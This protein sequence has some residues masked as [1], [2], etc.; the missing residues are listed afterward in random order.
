MMVET[1][2]SRSVRVIFA[3][4]LAFGAQLAYAQMAQEPVVQRVEITGSSIRR[5]ASETALP[6]TV[7][8]RADIEKSGVQSTEEL[9]AQVNAVSSAGGQVSAAQSGLTTYGKSAVSLRGI[10]SDKTLVLVNG[11][12]LANFAGGA[13]AGADVNVNAI[14]LAAIDRVEVLQDGASGVYGSD[15][16]AGVV[17]FILRKDFNGIEL[18][19]MSGKPTQGGGAKQHKLG[20]VAGWGDYDKD[21]FSIVGSLAYEK[22]GNLLGAARDFA[23]TDT[24]RPY[25]EGGATETGRI[26]GTWEHP[27]GA[28]VLDA[29]T[30]ARSKDNPYGISSTG[31]G[32]PLAKLGQ[33][34]TM[35]M[36]P[37]PGLGFVVGA[38]GTTK[39]GAN[40]TF[41][42]GPFVSLVPNREFVGSTANFR[43][44]IDEENELYAEGLYSSNSFTNPI[45]PAPLRQG[46]YAGNTSFGGTGV[47]PALLIYPSNPNYKIAAD[48]LNSVGLGAMVGK[49]L[50]VSQ[51]TFLL[52]P[53]TTHD[54]A[55][56]DRFVIGA[57]G[58]LGKLDYDVAYVR[59]NSKTDGAVVDG[60]AS[61]F[62]LSKVLNNPTTFWNP[63]APLGQQSPE[64]AKLID[65]TKYSG[66]TIAASSKNEGIDAKVSGTLGQLSGGAIGIA[67]GMQA[68]DE[69]YTLTPAPATLSGDVIGLG[70]AITAVKAKRTVWALFAETEVPFTKT[71]MGDLAVRQDSYS[72]FGKTFNYKA[73]MKFQ[74]LDTVATRAS[75]GTGFRA[76][77]LTQLY[78][79]QQIN[80]SEQFIDPA[81]KEAG[82]IQVTSIGGGN[83]NLGPEKSDQLSFGI[84]LSPV[85]QL[86]ASIDF[87]SIKVKGLIATPSAQEIAN[88]FRNGSA[89]YGG[90]VD[91]TPGGEMSLIRQLSANVNSLKTEGIDLDL[92]YKESFMGGRFQAVLDGTYV[93]KYDLIN[94][95][96]K[97][98]HS[99]GTIVDQD[100]NPL[101][102]S[103]TGVILRWKHNLSASYSKSDWNVTVTQRFYKGYETGR[104]IAQDGEDIGKRHFVNNQALYDLVGSYNGLIK[105]LRMSVGVRNLF[106]KAPPLFINNGSQFQS[107]YDVYQY[108]PRGRFVY[109]NAAYKF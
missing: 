20:V 38:P 54:V 73:S 6:V 87:Y 34:G 95:S 72:D 46:F 15:A 31:Y 25:Y 97:T 21:R 58:T 102:A 49:P 24:N 79:P 8:S 57:K 96:G 50:A 40:C 63:W 89:G 101:V 88:G 44:K 93:S 18:S 30:N 109:V 68:R 81:H 1:V 106:D 51:R 4:G 10:G 35:G 104:E 70:G 32:N 37:R 99:V 22:E 28:T 108:D 9:L 52:G 23:K 82:Q 90:L 17:N 16:I 103:P 41:D 85:K 84:V 64:V 19:G 5:V 29:G 69:S 26:E 56:Q 47:E 39:G 62:G 77:A 75:V 45:Q 7:V 80:T 74:P 76:P 59:N 12:R 65:S 107:G 100:G 43:F 105:G 42:T 66:P 27:G 2:L 48:Y 61:I 67:A 71:L 11:R 92:R 53:R 94:T 33:C 86:S 98:E 36:A 3:G 83:P 91:L 13:T 78:A 60:F 14:P 55:K